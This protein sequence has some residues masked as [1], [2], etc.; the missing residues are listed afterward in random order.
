IEQRDKALIEHLHDS[1]LQGGE[2]EALIRIFCL[3]ARASVRF[4]KERIEELAQ[5]AR[6]LS[7]QLGID[8]LAVRDS[9]RLQDLL[10]F[11]HPEESLSTLPLL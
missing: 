9:V 2:R 7:Q 6:T 11:A 3:L 5:R 1:L 10:V 4:G 8:P